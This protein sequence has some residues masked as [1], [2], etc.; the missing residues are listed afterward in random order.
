MVD[1]VLEKE[2]EAK[3][4]FVVEIVVVAANFEKV[5]VGYLVIVS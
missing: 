4:G 5:D 3:K 1:V 2:G